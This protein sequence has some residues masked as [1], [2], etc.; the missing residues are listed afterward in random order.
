MMTGA[1]VKTIEAAIAEPPSE[2]TLVV[3]EQQYENGEFVGLRRVYA[4]DA[5]S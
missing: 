2:P 3:F 5:N 1:A 4:P